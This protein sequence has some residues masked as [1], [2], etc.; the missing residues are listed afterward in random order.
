MHN[1]FNSVPAFTT[2]YAMSTFQFFTLMTSPKAPLPSHLRISNSFFRRDCP[3]SLVG[4]KGITAVSS[5]SSS[6]FSAT[7]VKMTQNRTLYLLS[8]K[9]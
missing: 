5:S 2:I 8:S 4:M 3:P 1:C 6:D 7:G 9:K